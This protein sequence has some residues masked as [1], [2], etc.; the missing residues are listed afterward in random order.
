MRELLSFLVFVSVVIAANL[1]GL[2]RATNT[3]RL[4]RREYAEQ[5]HPY[6]LFASEGLRAQHVQDRDGKRLLRRSSM[7]NS[8]RGEI[9][10]QPQ[11]LRRSIDSSSEASTIPITNQ[12]SYQN[13]HVDRGTLETSTTAGPRQQASGQGYYE[14]SLGPVPLSSEEQSTS[15]STPLSSGEGHDK[16]GHSVTSPSTESTLG[17]VTEMSGA[18]LTQP[19]GMTGGGPHDPVTGSHQQF[20]RLASD[21][22]TAQSGRRFQPFAYSEVMSRVDPRHSTQSVRDRRPDYGDHSSVDPMAQYG[23]HAADSEGTTLM[24]ARVGNSDRGRL[25]RTQMQ[26]FDL[27]QR[28]ALLQ[29]RQF[30]R[31][32]DNNPVAPQKSEER[33]VRGR[34]SG[35]VTPKRPDEQGLGE[36]LKGLATPNKSDEQG[37]RG[38]LSGLV[39]PKKSDE[40][41]VRG[42]LSGPATPQKPDGQRLSGLLSG[43]ATPRKLDEQG[44]RGRFSGLA[45]PKKPD[46]RRVSGRLSSLMGVRTESAQSQHHMPH[47]AEEAVEQAA[48]H[49]PFGART[50]EL[51]PDQR[52]ARLRSLMSSETGSRWSAVPHHGDGTTIPRQLRKMQG[53]TGRLQDVFRR[54]RPNPALQDQTAPR[55]KTRSLRRLA[56]RF[57]DRPRRRRRVK[58][59][60]PQKVR[61]LFDPTK[62]AP[63]WPQRPSRDMERPWVSARYRESMDEQRRTMEQERR[64]PGRPSLSTRFRQSLDERRPRTFGTSRASTDEQQ[65]RAHGQQLGPLEEESRQERP[66]KTSNP[67]YDEP[68]PERPSPL[69]RPPVQPQFGARFKPHFRLSEHALEQHNT[70]R[71]H[72]QAPEPHEVPPGVLRAESL[73]S[74]SGSGLSTIYET[75]VGTQKPGPARGAAGG[76]HGAV[77][78]DW[79]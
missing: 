51:T 2:C 50:P 65:R 38:R 6:V 49:R 63:A 46:R 29:A 16:H 11:L 67:L 72:E 73:D 76:S 17:S 47:T 27:R 21:P 60:M 70:P 32:S 10:R 45:T 57:R 5:K 61:D 52:A 78:G 33:G 62:S 59:A 71:W 25:A 36:R 15:V 28:L 8:E 40:Q 35:L 42:R 9:S 23:P 58:I 41:D 34:L 69:R 55:R 66:Q 26:G 7:L 4:A 68:K 31:E 53:F 39:T 56:Q 20:D 3:S 22:V 43:L 75:A 64:A 1:L 44:M 18:S 12:P 48:R 77:P 13:F 54:A 19:V 79:L 30:S 24:Q 37:F 14:H 74:S